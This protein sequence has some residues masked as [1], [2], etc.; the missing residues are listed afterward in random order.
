MG[1]EI[2]MVIPNW[3]HPKRDN[4][5]FHPM[6]DQSATDAFNEWIEEFESFK[7]G[8]LH[9]YAKKYDYDVNNPYAAFCDWHGTL[10]DAEY[11]HPH[12]CESSATWIQVYETVS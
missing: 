12:W 8:D 10:P 2:R 11:F 1:R 4:G 6:F 3:E 5:S 7:K 9:K